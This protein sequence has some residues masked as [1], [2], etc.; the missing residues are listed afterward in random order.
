MKAYLWNTYEIQAVLFFFF[1]I[2][3]QVHS[4]H[5]MQELA[6]QHYPSADA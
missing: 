4:N 6:L 5:T 1:N 3:M 2:T